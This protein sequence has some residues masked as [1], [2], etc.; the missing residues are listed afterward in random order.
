[1]TRRTGF[2]NKNSFN[3]MIIIVIILASQSIIASSSAPSD[4]SAL[5]KLI[6]HNEDPR[7]GVK[8]LAFFLVTHDFDAV[9]KKDRVEVQIDG[10]PYVL[11]PN[12]QSPGLANVTAASLERTGQKN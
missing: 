3:V 4:D 10:T 1:M 9:P 6:T 5:I 12:G 8:D 11:V 2:Y 7:M